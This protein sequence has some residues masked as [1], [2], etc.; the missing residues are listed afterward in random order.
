MLLAYI[1]HVTAQLR[2]PVHRRGSSTSQQR[3]E[4]AGG[5]SHPFLGLFFRKEQLKIYVSMLLLCNICSAT[6]INSTW[7]WLSG[8]LAFSHPSMSVHSSSVIHTAAAS[9]TTEQVC[10]SARL[11]LTLMQPKDS[12]AALQTTHFAQNLVVFHFQADHKPNWQLTLTIQLTRS[13]SRMSKPDVFQWHT[14]WAVPSLAYLV[15]LSAHP[16]CRFQPSRMAGTALHFIDKQTKKRTIP[17]KILETS[18]FPHILLQVALK[19]TTR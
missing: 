8:V 4:T 16:T 7:L 18:T 5:I 14:L 13:F 2:S 10:S 15:Q 6:F 12:N 3:L 17:T 11:C 1:P 19:H 9:R